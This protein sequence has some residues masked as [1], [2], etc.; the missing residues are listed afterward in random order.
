M[1]TNDMDYGQKMAYLNYNLEQAKANA[2]VGRQQTLL[3]FQHGQEMERLA[4]EQGHDAAMQYSKFHFDKALSEQ[5]FLQAEIL[6]RQ[7]LE[8]QASENAKDRLLENMKIELQQRGMDMAQFNALQAEVEAGRI[9]PQAAQ[10]YLQ[11][12]LYQSGYMTQLNPV[13][14]ETQTR[15]A[16]KAEYDS[17]Q[18]QFALT[19][20]NMTPEEAAGAFFDWYNENQYGEGSVPISDMI[21]DSSMLVGSA[22]PN[23]ANHSDYQALYEK[24]SEWTPKVTSSGG[25]WFNGQQVTR[26]FDKTPAAGTPFTID[27]TL[28]VATSGVALKKEGYPNTEYFTAKD[29]NTG[30][31]KTFYANDFK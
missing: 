7:T 22:N 23:D 15:N 16:I 29:V 25:G 4:S 13:D 19:H 14:I 5:D 12:M 17:M 8:F 18:Y 28:Y 24:A 6:Q 1:Q 21:V 30:D 20:P 2:D 9:E 11:Q 3:M 10:S 26:R 27:G 31:V